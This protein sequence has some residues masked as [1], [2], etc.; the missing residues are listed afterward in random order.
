[1]VHADIN[2]LMICP[3]QVKGFLSILNSCPMCHE[4]CRKSS[5]ALGDAAPSGESSSRSPR[6]L[7]AGLATLAVACA[8]AWGCNP[9]LSLEGIRSQ[10]EA[11][12]FA[13]T[14]EP[15]RKLLEVT[16]DDPELNHLY[17]LALLGTRR[18]DLAIWPLRKAARHPDWAIEG[19][20]LLTRAL[21]RGGSPEDAVEA[22]NRVL[23]LAPDRVDAL[24]LLIEARMASRQHEEMLEDTERLLALEPGDL[25]ALMAR[26]AALLGLE[27]V[28]EAEQALAAARGAMADREDKSEWRARLCAASAT[29]AKEKGDAVGAEA[30]WSDCL[31]QFPGEEMVVFG[32][33]E[34]F[35]ERAQP[36]R[37]LEILRRALDENPTHLPFIEALAHRLGASGHSA[38]AEDLLRAATR[39]GV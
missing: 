12:E 3:P 13:T 11:G 32:G 22:A 37:G 18:P 25:Q 5:P 8:L 21:L 24:R 38:E 14:V 16:P 17:G 34:F 23:G 35:G 19:G 39:D 10:Q 7:R 9:G 26:L 2:N 6:L 1:M 28:D 27:R 31:E 15:L 29:F 4:P 30:Q 33:I 20:L 36:A